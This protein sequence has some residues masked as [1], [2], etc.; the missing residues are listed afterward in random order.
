M[1]ILALTDS[2]VDVISAHV[3]DMVIQR[4][5][6]R[7][8]KQEKLFVFAGDR[9]CHE[10]LLNVSNRLARR[11]R[12]I[13][14]L[15]QIHH[16]NAVKM[17]GFST[18]SPVAASAEDEEEGRA[19]AESESADSATTDCLLTLLSLRFVPNKMMAGEAADAD[20]PG[21]RIFLLFESGAEL[22][23]DVECPEVSLSDQG[24]ARRTPV[25]PLHL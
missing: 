9:F 2:D 1:K 10:D 23:L 11:Y 6:M 12:R 8:L 18:L 14:A 21:G 7:Y 16:V 5:A 4:S 13:D 24:E 15:V 20:D 19:D 25:R 17:K 22:C 3:Q